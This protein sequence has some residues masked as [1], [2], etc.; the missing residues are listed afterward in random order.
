M[1]VFGCYKEEPR[2]ET[3]CPRTKKRRK[4]ETTTYTPRYRQFQYQ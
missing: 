3:T 4:E 2:K 1:E